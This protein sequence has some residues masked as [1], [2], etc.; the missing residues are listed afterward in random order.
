MYQT[1]CRDIFWGMELVECDALAQV[2]GR[3]PK[4]DDVPTTSRQGIIARW[5]AEAFEAGN[6]IGTMSCEDI[7]CHPRV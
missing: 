6:G 3:S 5:E 4:F 1:R 2:F 7:L